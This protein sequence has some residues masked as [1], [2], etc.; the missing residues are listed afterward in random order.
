VQ[1][2]VDAALVVI[3]MIVVTQGLDLLKELT[4]GSLR[5]KKHVGSVT[6]DRESDLTV[7]VS[8]SPVFDHSAQDQ[9]HGLPGAGCPRD[10]WLPCRCHKPV[11]PYS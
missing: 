10:L 7:S 6:A 4:H 5:W 11:T 8:Q 9:T 1:A 3:T 2:L